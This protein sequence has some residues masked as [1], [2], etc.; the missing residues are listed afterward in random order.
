MIG[1]LIGVVV[2]AIIIVMVIIFALSAARKK[3]GGVSNAMT[4]T[5]KRFCR[6]TTCIETAGYKYQTV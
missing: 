5:G 3:E 6:L 1:A 4:S 2:L